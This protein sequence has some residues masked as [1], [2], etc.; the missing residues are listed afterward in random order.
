MSPKKENENRIIESQISK[1]ATDH[2]THLLILPFESKNCTP[3]N[4]E[5]FGKKIHDFLPSVFKHNTTIS[6]KASLPDL[7]SPILSFIKNR[8][9]SQSLNPV[10]IYEVENSEFFASQT[11]SQVLKSKITKIEESLI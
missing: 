10:Q 5:S 11:N 3:Q 4:F 7:N 2:K 1:K 9:F 8:G 6:V